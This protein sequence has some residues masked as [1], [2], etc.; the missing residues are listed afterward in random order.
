MKRFR[1]LLKLGLMFEVWKLICLQSLIVSLPHQCPNCVEI[2]SRPEVGV[3]EKFRLVIVVTNSFF[4]P[5]ALRITTNP[6][7]TFLYPFILQ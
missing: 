3:H 4:F 2:G 5:K 1:F 7:Q 6:S